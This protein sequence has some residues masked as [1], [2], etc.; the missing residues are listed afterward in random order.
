MAR[1]MKAG[2]ARVIFAPAVASL[3][4]PTRAE[5]T[6]GTVLAEPGTTVVVG[7]KEMNGWET[8][9]SDI[10][11]PD[12]NTTFDG[13]IPGRKAASSP[14]VTFYDDTAASTIRTAQ[15]EGTA[16]YMII[17]PYGDT[18]AKRCEVWPCRVSALNDSQVTNANEAA[19]FTAMYA[20]TGE[21]DKAAAIPA[22]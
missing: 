22:A 9:P 4:A 14:S 1:H 13:T 10:A 18:E 19:T 12:V 16:G 6:A 3:A 11:V 20:T 7:M 15:A 5:I 8:S 21:P 17:M 2:T